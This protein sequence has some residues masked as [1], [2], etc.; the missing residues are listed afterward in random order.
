MKSTYLQMRISNDPQCP[1]FSPNDS[2]YKLPL[3]TT[4]SPLSRVDTV[5]RDS[6]VHRT[7]VQSVHCCAITTSA[8]QR[9]LM[10]GPSRQ[11]GGP[12][13]KPT[14]PTTASQ[15]DGAIDARQMR[16]SHVSNRSFT[17]RPTNARRRRAAFTATVLPPPPPTTTS[18]T[19]TM[20]SA[21][22]APADGDVLMLLLTL[23]TLARVEMAPK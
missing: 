2:I 12:I 10:E 1:R 4:T 9:R 23:L 20:T 19:M 5:L 6:R 13:N 11:P 16:T 17:A 8:G 7:A 14:P 21:T 15:R 18:P 3:Q 22:V